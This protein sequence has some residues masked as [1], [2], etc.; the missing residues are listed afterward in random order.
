MKPR[1]L[2]VFAISEMYCRCN[3]KLR[4]HCRPD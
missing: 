1:Y 4:F 2:D 3:V